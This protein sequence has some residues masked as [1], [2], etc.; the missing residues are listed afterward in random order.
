[1]EGSITQLG[2]SNYLINCKAP[3]ISFFK[4]GYK[5]YKNF[6]KTTRSIPFKNKFTYND[7]IS[8]DINELAKYGDLITNIMIEVELPTLTTTGTGASCGW[9]NGVGNAIIKSVDL[10]IGGNIIDRH[11]SEWLD[12]WSQLSVRPGVQNTYKRMIKKFDVHNF[13]TFKGGRVFIPLQFWFCQ[14]S[15]SNNN[16]ALNLPLAALLNNKIELIIK[17]RSFNELVISSDDSV[18]TLL[19]IEKANMMLDFVILQKEERIQLQRTPKQLF[20]ITQLQFIEENIHANTREL[21][22]SLREFKYPI[23]EL[24]WIVRRNDSETGKVYFNYGNTLDTTKFDPIDTT[25]ISFEGRTRIDEMSS[26]Y[27]TNIEPYK[28]HDN[29]PNSFIHTYSFSLNPENFSQ[30]SGVCNFSNLHDPRMQFKFRS[31]IAA[32]KLIIF[33]I[34]YNVLQTDNNGNA[35]LLHNLSK[36]SPANFPNAID[37]CEETNQKGKDSQDKNIKMS[38]N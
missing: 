25:S 28:I 33:G 27:F 31:G 2:L 15:T 23:S 13:D 5:N 22:V 12:V 21:N 26:E 29:V 18:P 30:P 16:S 35:W 19:E 14:N 11:L 17:T 10:K 9:C 37:N 32:S 4:H 3:A 24:L 1:M 20:M 38:R 36:K 34:N 8:I 6:V 7:T